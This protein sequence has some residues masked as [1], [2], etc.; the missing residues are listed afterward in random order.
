MRGKQYTHKTSGIL[1]RDIILG[2]QDG[3]VN[4]LGLILGVYSAT[5]DIKVIIV[6][7]LAAGLAEAVSMA[8]VA[9]T[10][11]E[12]EKEF[13]QRAYE[14]EKENITNFPEKEKEELKEVYRSKG[15]PK[16]DVESIAEVITSNP[17]VWLSTIMA[18]KL[19]LTE[20]ELG[21]KLKSSLVIG[22]A[23]TI[24]SIIPIAPFFLTNDQH[25]GMTVAIIISSISLFVLGFVKGKFA[26]RSSFRSGM[27]LLLI[28]MSA[29]II[30]FLIG[31]VFKNFYGN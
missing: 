21:G 20:G 10:S 5:S 30:G 26:K 25:Q 4:V 14:Q 24:G 8:A 13:Y 1:F 11:F 19:R 9:Y 31:L 12:A 6:S 18:E 29:G 16:K 27:E 28:G 7:G 3:L 22:L 15:L 23:A 17:Q 2:G